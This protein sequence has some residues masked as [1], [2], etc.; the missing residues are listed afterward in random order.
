MQMDEQLKNNNTQHR[1]VADLGVNG[2]SVPPA[3]NLLMTHVVFPTVRA[4]RAA[5]LQCVRV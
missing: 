4:W 3:N 2:I 1:L 5:A